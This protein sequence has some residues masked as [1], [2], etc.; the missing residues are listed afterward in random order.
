MGALCRFHAGR[1]VDAL[2]KGWF[3]AGTFFV[4]AAGCL[5]IGLIFGFVAGGKLPSEPWGPLVMD[6]FCGALTTFSSFSADCVRL[7]REGRTA[8]AC[9]NMVLSLAVCTGAAPLGLKLAAG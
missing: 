4:N 6:G 7:L 5:L 2:F 8:T 9:A 1:A 3:P